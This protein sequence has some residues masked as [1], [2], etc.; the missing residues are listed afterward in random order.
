MRGVRIAA[1]A[2]GSEPARLGNPTPEEVY[3]F[4]DGFRWS[5]RTELPAWRRVVWFAGMPHL[6]PLNRT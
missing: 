3:R 6:R 5:I 2:A 4:P 1:T